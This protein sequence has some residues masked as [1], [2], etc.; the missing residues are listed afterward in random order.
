MGKHV[1]KQKRITWSDKEPPYEVAK[2]GFKLKDVQLDFEGWVD[3]TVYL[4]MAFEIVHTQTTEKKKKSCWWTGMH[5]DGYRLLHGEKV[6][7][8]KMIEDGS[9]GKREKSIKEENITLF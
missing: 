6:I 8:W 7:C 2:L 3:A 5:W 4:P 9:D 1:K